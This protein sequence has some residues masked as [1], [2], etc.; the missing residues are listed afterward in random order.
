MNMFEKN[1]QEDEKMEAKH[2][3]FFKTTARK[4]KFTLGV[5]VLN[6]IC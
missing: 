1:L 4:R 2:G 5:K 3:L 6:K